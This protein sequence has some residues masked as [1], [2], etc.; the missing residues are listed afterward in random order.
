MLI[1]ALSVGMGLFF[2]GT[3][4]LVPIFFASVPF[5]KLVFTACADS[6]SSEN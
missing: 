5:Y 4:K 1:I 6:Q 3:N 2:P